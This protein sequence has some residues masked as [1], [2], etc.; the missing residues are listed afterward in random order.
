MRKI[1]VTGSLAFDQIMNMPGRFAD[2]I[3]PDK[4]HILN[5]SFTVDTLRREYGGTGGNTVYNLAL[6]GMKPK[7]VAMVGDD[8]DE[9]K[10]RLQGVG[11][12][13]SGVVVLR[14]ERTAL[15][16]V[17]TDRDDNQIW[18]FYGGAFFRSHELELRNLD[19]DFVLVGPLQPRVAIKHVQECIQQQVGYMFDPA[20]QI[21]NYS[22]NEL[23]LAVGNAE[24]VIGN[25]YEVALMRYK[26]Q[27]TSYPE[28]QSEVRYGASKLQAKQVWITTLGA[29]GSIIKQGKM[30]YKIKA[31]KVKSSI[32]P[33]GAGDAY[34]AG[35][36][37]GYLQGQALQVCGQMG[38]V[39]AAYTVEKYGTQTHGFTWREFAQR[40]KE[41]FGVALSF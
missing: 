40:Y 37:A 10:D 24:V 6:L 3:L 39:A 30:E 13:V 2:H 7:L 16:T 35:F 9:Y 31:A 25:D 15:G 4:L 5:V 29:K 8:G 33:T 23:K 34:R 26:L 18:S 11:V 38:A 22:K 27:A 19:N 36:L 41:N 14:G 21:P 28:Q 17:M 32:D 20:F 12:D 1:I